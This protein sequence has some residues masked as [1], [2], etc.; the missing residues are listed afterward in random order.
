MVEAL[1]DSSDI[2]TKFG[3]HFF[4]A[5]YTL[6]ST[7]L[8]KLRDNL[9]QY[10]KKLK[11]RPQESSIGMESDV[12]LGD[13]E[14]IAWPLMDSLEL[15]E[16]HG[17]GNPRPLFE[18][19]DIQLRTLKKMGRESQHLRMGLSDAGGRALAAV[20]FGFASKYPEL[21][22]GQNLTVRGYLNKNDFQGTS[23]IQFVLQEITNE[24]N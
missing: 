17:S 10:Y 22:T 21:K 7:K 23:T 18:F 12:S 16:P 20:G 11:K 24:Q 13:L 2:L 6:P 4:A 5:G 1:R 15:L 9:N 14:T 3:G 19:A 8:N